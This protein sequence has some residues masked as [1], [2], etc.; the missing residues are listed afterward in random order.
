MA[1]YHFHH[2]LLEFA[3][4]FI[5]SSNCMC[6]SSKSINIFSD[7]LNLSVMVFIAFAMMS[8]ITSALACF[9]FFPSPFTMFVDASGALTEP[10]ASGGGSSCSSSLG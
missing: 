10:L 9:C 3:I 7:S 2:L 5:L 6:F 8:S 4:S 1:N